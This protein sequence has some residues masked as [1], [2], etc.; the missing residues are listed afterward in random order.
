MSLNPT[1]VWGSLVLTLVLSASGGLGQT[2]QPA[3]PAAGDQSVDPAPSWQQVID[4][5]GDQLSAQDSRALRAA[6]NHDPLVRSFT[7]E[8]PTTIERLLASTSQARLLGAHAYAKTPTTLASDLAND[9]QNAGDVVPEQVKKDMAPAEGAAEKR[10]NET[11]AQWLTQVLQ[12]RK[13]QP[14]AVLV[15]WPTERNLLAD[16]PVRRALFV[17]VKAQLIGGA[18]V[19]QQVTFGD[20]LESAR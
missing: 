4:R 9:F 18:Y 20:P 13:D 8:A 10:A 6:L 16:K 7:S 17:L 5:L 19:V 12:P 11:A 1:A 14:V 3:A 15:F 2:T